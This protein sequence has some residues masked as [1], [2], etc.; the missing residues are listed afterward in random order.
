MGRGGPGGRRGPGSESPF[1]SARRELLVGPWVGAAA[2]DGE[3][4]AAAVVVGIGAVERNRLP[5]ALVVCSGIW[6]V[7]G[8]GALGDE[9]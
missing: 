8:R 5:M 9:R 3:A 4:P 6:V 7:V 1:L 2:V